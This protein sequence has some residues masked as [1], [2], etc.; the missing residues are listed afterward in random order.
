MPPLPALTLV[1]LSSRG[2]GLA[3]G[4]VDRPVNRPASNAS[5][6]LKHAAIC[7]G[8]EPRGVAITTGFSTLRV[9]D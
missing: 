3:R 7:R 8:H 6:R 9:H 5:F 2:R 1:S 4:H